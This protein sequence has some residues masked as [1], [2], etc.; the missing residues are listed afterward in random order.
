MHTRHSRHSHHDTLLAGL[1]AFLLLSFGPI[2][3]GEVESE[4]TDPDYELLEI[5]LSGNAEER[6]LIAED[7]E[8][9]AD[10]ILEFSAT[11]EEAANQLAAVLDTEP[12][13]WIRFTCLLSIVEWSGDSDLNPF[14]LNLL[15]DGRPADRWPVLAWLTEESIPEALPHLQALWPAPDR[16]WLKPLLVEALAYHQS[17]EH[18]DEFLH[19]AR[20]REPEEEGLAGIAIDAL[21]TLG[22][23]SAI[24]V[25]LRLGRANGPMATRAIKALSAWPDSDLARDG[26]LHFLEWG[27]TGQRS[28]ALGSLHQFDHPEVLDAR[29]R[30]VED[31]QAGLY[32]RLAAIDGLS[33]EEDPLVFPVLRAL[34]TGS[35]PG[36]DDLSRAAWKILQFNAKVVE[37]EEL[38]AFVQRHVI[39]TSGTVSIS[40]NCQFR[41]VSGEAESIP[42]LLV[43]PHNGTS[44]RCWAGPDRILPWEEQLVERMPAGYPVEISAVYEGPGGIMIQEYD[45]D[46]W[47]PM[48]QLAWRRPTAEEIDWPFFWDSPTTAD[49]DIPLDETYSETALNLQDAGLLDLFDPGP[50]TIG[51]A[52]V[53]DENRPELRD[54]L[55]LLAKAGD[56]PLLQEALAAAWSEME[57]LAAEEEAGEEP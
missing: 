14:F 56:A 24:P 12:D 10:E 37:D 16:P 55:L 3:A 1:T 5:F 8:D 11:P 32:L 31:S 13:P 46:C 30:L 38:D 34:A 47:L 7:C 41:G 23:E 22:D 26:L 45:E 29:L 25:L 18:V 6:L 17:M 53:I 2:Q 48:E 27:K 54:L 42:G 43:T 36:G 20:S 40:T 21:A 57:E 19:L 51:A 52:L 35:S 9:L 49:F 15:V 39:F 33:A 28:A 50:G 44:L 4:E